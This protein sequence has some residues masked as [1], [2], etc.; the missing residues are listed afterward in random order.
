MALLD[1][2]PFGVGLVPSVEPVQVDKRFFRERQL[3]LVAVVVIFVV[4][5][6]ASSLVTGFDF[7]EAL[8]DFPAGFVWFLQH[9]TPNLESFEKF[10]RI[11]AALAAT[12]LDS[13]AAGTCAAVLAYISAIL[14][15]RSVGLGGAIPVV[16]RA[17]ASVFRNVPIVA[18]AFLLLFSFKQSEFTGFLALFLQSYGFLTRSLLEMIDEISSGPVEALKA[19]GATYLQLIACCVIPLSI[20]QSISWVL[21]NIETNIRDATLVGL[22][23]GTGVGFVFDVFYKSFRYETCGLLLLCVVVVVV[24]CEMFSNFIRR[25][26]Q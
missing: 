25:R 23:T 1:S 16:I 20:T 6:G 13:I 8:H 10:D 22:L 5:C 18:W 9:F 17:I 24:A 26:V 2:S 11:L 7:I 15:S 21:Y 12:L 4:I 14:G 19:T 3:T